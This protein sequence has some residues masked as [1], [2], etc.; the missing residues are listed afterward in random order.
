[1]KLTMVSI[2]YR[3]TLHTRF[4]M[5]PI[6][7]GKAVVAESVINSMLNDAGCTARGLTYSIG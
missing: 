7:N 5:C 2:T 6:I 4:V 1:M 3:G